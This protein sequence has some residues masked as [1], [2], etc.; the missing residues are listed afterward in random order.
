MRKIG[1]AVVMQARQTNKIKTLTIVAVALTFWGCEPAPW[2]GS[3]NRDEYLAHCTWRRKI[4][5]RYRPKAEVRDKLKALRD[6]VD[7]TLFLGTWCSDSRKH[8][9]RFMHLYAD[10][11]IRRMTLVGVDTSKKD[12]AGLWKTFRVDSVPTFIFFDTKG[13]E[14]GRIKVKPRKERMEEALLRILDRY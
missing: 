12:A 5:S 8:V 11:P 3:F 2:V 13:V 14:L 6:S 9:P 4:A 1:R 10:L 7:V